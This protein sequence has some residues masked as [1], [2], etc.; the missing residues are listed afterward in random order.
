MSSRSRR[1]SSAASSGVGGESARV[2]K[3]PEVVAAD[4][5]FDVRDHGV[6]HLLE[7]LQHGRSIRRDLLLLLWRRVAPEDVAVDGDR[8]A[9]ERFLEIADLA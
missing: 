5:L 1:S 8:S 7:R 6:L 2:A 9:L 3:P 4:L